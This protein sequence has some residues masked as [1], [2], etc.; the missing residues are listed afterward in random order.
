MQAYQKE[1]KI[2][3]M[4]D[5]INEMHPFLKDFLRMLPNV[6]YVEYTH[7][8]SE[9]GADFVV[10]IEDTTFATENYVG[11]VAKATQIKQ[12][13][14]DGIVRQVDE[15]INIPRFINNGKKKINI[16]RVWMITTQDFTENAK[17]KASMY[18]KGKSVQIIDAERIV[19]LIDK[20]Y[21]DYWN[22]IS[23][24]VV[25]LLQKVR[26]KVM[27]EDKRY[28]LIPNLDPAFFIEPDVYRVNKKD[29]D[30]SGS[31]IKNIIENVNVYE[32]VRK[33][34]FI[35]LEAPMGY[36]K[37]KLLRHLAQYYCD[38]EIYKEFR[39]LP[40]HL[41][42]TE[43][44]IDG[45]F[46]IDYLDGCC[47]LSPEEVKKH[48][49]ILFLIDGFDE[50][51]ETIE[52]KIKHIKLMESFLIEKSNYSIVLATRGLRAFA[53][54][55][56]DHGLVKKYEIKSLSFAKLKVFLEK[57]CSSLNLKDRILE[58][59][60][61]SHLIKELPQCPI[62][63]ILLA[64]LFENNAKDLPSNLPELYGMYLEL[65][66][67]KWDIDKGIESPREYETV[68]AILYKIA[69]KIIDTQI[70]YLTYDEYNAII[71]DY[72]NERNLDIN[73]SK[74]DEIICTRSGLLVKDPKSNTVYYSHRTFV[75]YLYAKSMTMDSLLAADSR[76][77]NIAWMNIFY[78]YI[79]IKKDCEKYL[80]ELTAIV[81]S[82]EPEKW[83]KILNLSNF[84]LAGINTPYSFFEKNIY[85]IF[86]EAASLYK[87]IIK[88]E[89]TSFFSGLPQ[90]VILW[91][92]QF[93][94]KENYG[95]KF[96]KKAIET[97]TLLIDSAEVED[98]I[99]I[100]GL[101]LLGSVGMRL[102]EYEP[103]RYLFSKYKEKIPED[104]IIGLKG[105]LKN[106]NVIVEEIRKNEKWLERKIRGMHKKLLDEISKRPVK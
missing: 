92:M 13:D 69:Q 105:E 102:E 71:N 66:L 67:G 29:H 59:L 11:V 103:L 81:P 4:T 83:L 39:I 41:K 42:Y 57:L 9:F 58:D 7:G 52:D 76:A 10:I 25:S 86:L 75:E 1:R 43:M 8:Q 94:I 54:S 79:G 6:K 47:M 78:F 72:L 34:K 95:Y 65:I 14:I 53:D 100:I 97:T 49:R 32:L 91:W 26:T 93:L 35:I 38:N 85:K 60:K 74:I 61:Q 96:F 80:S 88:K 84:Y 99:K 3:E 2:K 55:I 17:T 19:E 46:S 73:K 104:I 21:P 64:R 82:S 31:D 30:Y 15:C 12:Q 87:S 51:S 36:G 18:F 5:E 89:T 101:F 62:A 33:E 37:S 20:H 24:E 48:A 40:I 28:C 27:E 98:D 77:F 44:F 68:Q 50:V 63:A 23:T 70:D 56:I 22:G 106:E 45:A 90:L 16:D